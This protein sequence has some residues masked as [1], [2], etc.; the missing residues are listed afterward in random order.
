L[1]DRRINR[2]CPKCGGTL[3][4]VDDVNGEYEECLQCGYIKYPTVVHLTD[5]PEPEE[6]LVNNEV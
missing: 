6:D 3:F 5:L 2:D 1:K 4:Y